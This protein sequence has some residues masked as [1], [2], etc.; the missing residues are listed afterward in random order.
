MKDDIH[1]VRNEP[2]QWRGLHAFNPAEESA[3]N[4]GDRR[5]EDERLRDSVLAEPGVDPANRNA[6]WAEWLD[7]RKRS[8]T[9]LGNLTVTM[10]AAL[11]GGPAAVLGAFFG[12]QEGWIGAIYVVVL[13]PVTEEIAKQFGMILLMER[14]PWR[15]FHSWQFPLVALAAALG[16]AVLENLL[17][18]HVYLRGMDP[19]LLARVATWRWSMGTLLHVVCA[20]IASAGLARLWKR[21]EATGETVD[22]SA[23]YPWFATAMVLHGLYN[24]GAILFDENFR[25]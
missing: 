2:T 7:R 9:V 15:I 20:L 3:E 10:M 5:S 19:D 6:A 25:F 8:T 4:G 16:F 11:I 1:S 24:L 21:R 13:G 14:K 18:I 17:Y 22:L 23:A 12:G